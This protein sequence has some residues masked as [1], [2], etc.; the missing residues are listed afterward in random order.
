MTF[1]R[2]WMCLLARSMDG[3]AQKRYRERQKLQRVNLQVRHRLG[4][5][6]LWNRRALNCYPCCSISPL[7]L[8]VCSLCLDLMSS[9]FFNNYIMITTMK[10]WHHEGM[11]CST[12]Q[13]ELE[14]LRAEVARLSQ[15]HREHGKLEV[16]CSLFPHRRRRF[17]C[18]GIPPPPT[19]QPYV[20][21]II[22]RGVLR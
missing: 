14:Q 8:P 17:F 3:R 18:W 10:Y 19:L 2:M 4:C 9:I 21:F 6:E 13:G 1:V 11:P 5:E 16:R 22:L 20:P 15:T 7:S 12:E